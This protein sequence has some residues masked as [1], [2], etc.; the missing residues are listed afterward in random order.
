MAVT[1]GR[2]T[3]AYEP[4]G[5][6]QFNE[7]LNDSTANGFNMTVSVGTERYTDI[8]PGVRGI[9]L[10]A[11]RLTYS[12]FNAALAI[13]GDVTVE[14]LMF[15]RVYPTA[16][17]V[18]IVTHAAAGENTADNV[19]YAIQLTGNNGALSW[20]SESGS[21]VNATY[22]ANLGPGLGLCHVAATRTSNVV[23]F[24]LNGRAQGAASS[25]LTTP[26]GGSNGRLFIGYPD[27]GY[28]GPECVMSSLKICNTAL[29]AAQ[30]ATEYNTTLGPV[31]GYV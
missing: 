23:Q 10:N 25:A 29:T 6:W 31:F 12:T 28:L 14:C 2:H 22:T 27:V 4:V 21:G 24:Y 9:G 13:T 30:I 15:L 8:Y 17:E 19:L 7:S 20:L 11:T 18:G 26:V 1:I 5:L 3:L 16:N